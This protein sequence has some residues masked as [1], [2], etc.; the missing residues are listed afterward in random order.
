MKSEPS[1]GVESSTNGIHHWK[2]S[3]DQQITSLPSECN[4]AVAVG[5]AGLKGTKKERMRRVN[6][7]L[8]EN[9]VKLNA[10]INALS[11]NKSDPNAP[12]DIRH[13]SKMF[14]IPYNTLRDNY[15]K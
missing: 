2:S 13:V 14:K 12:Q 6:Y 10:A 5:K 11:Q 3:E 9:A 4:D 1:S 7:R 15:L 8:P